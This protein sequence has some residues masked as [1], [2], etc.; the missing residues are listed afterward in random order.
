MRYARKDLLRSGWALG[1]E[2][3]LAG[4]PAVVRVHLGKGDVVLVGFR[5]QFR[6]Q[7][8]GT[9]KLLYNALQGASLDELPMAAHGAASRQRAGSRP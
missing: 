4:R 2:R 8:R 5:A 3:Y 6:G 9:F 1:G 7:P